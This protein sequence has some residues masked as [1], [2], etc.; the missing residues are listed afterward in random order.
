MRLRMNSPCSP[1]LG[2]RLV[3]M[4][5]PEATLLLVGGV[6]V[7]GGLAY[8]Y[9]AW[10][11]GNRPFDRPDDDEYGP[12]APLP[13]SSFAEDDD[14]VDE[15]LDESFPASDPPSFNTRGSAVSN[16]RRNGAVPARIKEK[17][18]PRNTTRRT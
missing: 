2:Q 10:R 9:D 5:R 18:A 3:R 7:V 14:L 1:T 6:V 15:A 16:A 11:R 4:I 12:D 8:L 17:P 13:P